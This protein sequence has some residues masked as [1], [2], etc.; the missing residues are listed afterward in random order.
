MY[1][2]A[3]WQLVHV[4]LHEIYQQ[5]NQHYRDN[6]NYSVC[7]HAWLRL[8]DIVSAIVHVA[9]SSTWPLVRFM[10]IIS[11]YIRCKG[12]HTVVYSCDNNCTHNNFSIL[13]TSLMHWYLDTVVLANIYAQDCYRVQLGSLSR[14][15]SI[16][17][18]M[19]KRWVG[20][21]TTCRLYHTKILREEYYCS[22]HMTKH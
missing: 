4:F 10:T 15:Y 5:V 12:S 14:L 7:R 9:K 1:W 18:F 22:L 16:A 19:A 6:T 21:D 11:D 8:H 3:H 2:R 17:H 13:E 20:V